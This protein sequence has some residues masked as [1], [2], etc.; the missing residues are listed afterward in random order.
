MNSSDWMTPLDQQDLIAFT[1]DL[2]RI[3]SYSGQ[4]EQIIRVIAQKMKSLGYDEVR[5][6]AMGNV[7]GRIGNG[8]KSIMFD[9]H[10]DTVAVND[11][12]KWDKPPFSGEIVNG[13]LHG[14]GSVDMKSGAAASIYAGAI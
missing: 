5:I 12:A 14:R 6:D 2:V 8:A 13:Y 11:E 1:Q 9:L 10:V 7:V 4:E 3:K